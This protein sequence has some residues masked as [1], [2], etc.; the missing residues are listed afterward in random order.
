MNVNKTDVAADVRSGRVC[1]IGS[2]TDDPGRQPI[3]GSTPSPCAE[4]GHDVMLSPATRRRMTD[5]SVVRC[6]DCAIIVAESRNER[7][8][9]PGRNDDQLSEMAE[10]DIDPKRWYGEK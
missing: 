8:I 9:D 6:A 1:V 10:N 5:L 3:A 4:C 2:R 7:W